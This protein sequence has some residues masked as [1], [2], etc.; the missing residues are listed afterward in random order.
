MYIMISAKHLF[1][2]WLKCKIRGGEMVHSGLPPP[3]YQ[4]MSTAV[5]SRNAVLLQN[6]ILTESSA[7]VA[8]YTMLLFSFNIY[9]YRLYAGGHIN[10]NNNN[11][12]NNNNNSCSSSCCC[13][14]LQRL[15][16]CCTNVPV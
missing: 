12:N 8:I 6:I 7:V 5:H 10:T 15:T 1:N 4:R 2:Q 16:R 13:C 3:N 11:N 9:V 14:I